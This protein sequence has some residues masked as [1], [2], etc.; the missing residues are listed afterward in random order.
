M[1]TK[2]VNV[3]ETFFSWQV[4][5][6]SFVRVTTKKGLDIPL[7]GIPDSTIDEGRQVRSVAL[8]GRDYTGLKPRM[9][10]REGDRV[11]LGDTLFV[12]KRDPGVA[13]T[14]PGS[15]T[16]TSIN[17]GERRALLSV[18]IEIDPSAEEPVHYP[19]LDG[20]R[21]DSLADDRIRE[22]LQSSGLW[23][24]FRTRPFSRVP[25][26]D[27]LPG[28]IFVTAIDTNPLA[29]DPKV[30]V[31]G[32][33]TYFEIGL[34]V[35]ARLTDGAV[36]LCTADEWPGPNGDCDRVQTTAFCGPHPAGLVGTHI[37][38][39]DPVAPDRIVWH[40]GYQDVIA[41][42]ALFA[43]GRISTRRIVSL[44][45]PAVVN[46]RLV[47]TRIG[48][49]INELTAGELDRPGAA[50]PD[51]RVISGSVLSGRN[52]AGPEAYLGRYHT[53]VSVIPSD[54]RRKL[55][56]WLRFRSSSFSFVP[57]FASRRQNRLEQLTT[58]SHGRQT[59]LIPVEA[60]EKVIPMA[61]PVTPLLH[62]LLIKDTDK[63]QMLGCLE[64]DAEDL[65]L[66]S[67]VCPGKNDYGS[68]LS[69]NLSQIEREG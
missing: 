66:C 61:F 10:V 29:A 57:M 46:P 44:G 38:H 11:S 19:D 21:I 18:V 7:A 41:I 63:A 40:L 4:N 64:L 12:D 26:S 59:A 68:V 43:T 45:G 35:I 14:A 28:S 30:V 33:E 17:R 47:A 37:H 5:G 24:A 53:Q 36:H 6:E 52:A 55:F 1:R 58:A 22:V 50:G 69:T 27:S 9:M 49:S 31:A 65:A 3:K 67:F 25:F 2:V 54:G 8:L 62:A 56:D 15:G 48:A 34:A 51:P 32:R 60:F 16:V 42:G 23:T 13:Y 20:G 39:L